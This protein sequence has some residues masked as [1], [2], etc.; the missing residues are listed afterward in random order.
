VSNGATGPGPRPGN[1]RACPMGAT[2]GSGPGPG[3]GAIGHALT[4]SILHLKLDLEVLGYSQMCRQCHRHSAGVK[5]SLKTW[6]QF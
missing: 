3:P 2:G 6:M 1:T 5:S 4:C